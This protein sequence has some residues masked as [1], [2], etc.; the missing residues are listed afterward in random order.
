MNVK[1][2]NN[3]IEANKRSEEICDDVLD[4]LYY[5]HGRVPT[6][7]DV[8]SELTI[9]QSKKDLKSADKLFFKSVKDAWSYFGFLKISTYIE[10]WCTRRHLEYKR[11]V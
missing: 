10:S 7:N 3:L 9:L 6:K 11:G 1:E 4:I 2:L 8:R 5:K